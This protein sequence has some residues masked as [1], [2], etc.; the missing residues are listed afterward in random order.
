[1]K[2]S[3]SSVLTTCLR[4][5]LPRRYLL[6]QPEESS[7]ACSQH[8]TQRKRDASQDTCGSLDEKAAHLYYSLLPGCAIACMCR[9]AVCIP[10]SAPRPHTRSTRTVGARLYAATWGAGRC[11]PVAA[12]NASRSAA[13]VSPTP[14]PA[15]PPMP[16]PTP[17]P[18]ARPG[19]AP[20]P[21]PLAVYP[22]PPCRECAAAVWGGA[23]AVAP[24]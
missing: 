13:I 6:V 21:K 23:D 7:A 17:P 24:A 12:K 19:D 18:I 20:P 1:M 9:V 22:D 4:C 16:A 10:W 14:P 3:S 8:A 15:P 11:T 5:S 2:A